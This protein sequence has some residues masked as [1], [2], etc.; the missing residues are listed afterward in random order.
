M[1]DRSARDMSE[2][3]YR[4]WRI[5][6]GTQAGIVDRAQAKRVGF[7]DR[8]IRYRVRSGRWQRVHEGVYATFTG[9]LKREAQLWAALRRAGEG[10]MLSHE[11]AAEVH[12]LVDRSVSHTIH[13]IVP[14]RRRPIRRT[15]TRGVV[16]HR[17]AE[18]QP[19]L[20]VTWKLPRTRI[21]DTVLD[22]IDAA[23][24]F[25][26]AYGWIARAVS[27]QLTSTAMLRASMATRS[28]LRYREQLSVALGESDDGVRSGLELRYARDVEQAHGL[29]AAQRQARREIAGRAHYRDNWYAEYRVCVEVDGPAY[30]RDE[31]TWQDKRRDNRNLAEDGAQTFR[32]GPVE[33]TELACESAAMVAVTLARNGWQGTA[34]PCRRRGCSLRKQR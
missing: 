6:L 28:R 12:G 15:S 7:S 13:I 25:Q 23:P 18:S 32:F 16:I 5:L 27:R 21:E 24:N 33:V 19:Q 34:R 29:P 20:P 4:E 10:A 22:L 2:R 9:P 3:A 17:S 1:D 26:V 14:I 11:T 8:Q 30:H 31:Q